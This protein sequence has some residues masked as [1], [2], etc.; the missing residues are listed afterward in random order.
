LGKD[1]KSI[2]DEQIVDQNISF[3]SDKYDL[4]VKKEVVTVEQLAK[5]V[6]SNVFFGFIRNK[7]DNSGIVWY[8]SLSQEETLAKLT[9]SKNKE[10]TD[11][12]IFP[13]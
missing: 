8:S 6:H 3:I 10:F 11:K 5:L 1:N 13:K 7:N 4:P 9:S 12:I 2:A